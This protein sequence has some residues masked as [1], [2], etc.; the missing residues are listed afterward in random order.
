MDPLVKIKE[1]YDGGIIP[2]KTYSLI[3]KRFPITVSGINRV[4][5]ASGM[6]FPVAYVDP[7][8]TIT[9]PDPNSYQYGILFARTIPVIHEGRLQ[10]VIQISAP[11]VA[12]GLKGTV[13]AILAHEFLHYLE[14]VRRASQMEVVSD[15]ISASLFENVYADEARLFEPRV[16]FRDRTLLAHITKRFPSGFRDYRLEDKAVKLWVEKGLPKNTVTLDS[17][18]AKIPIDSISK[19]RLDPELAEK[20]GELQLKSEKIRAKKIY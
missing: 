2:E 5:K 18:T 19:I 20:I 16:V 8:I 12:Y 11:L 6:Q 7:S 10:V 9:A 3:R 14:L 1:A 15:E 13:H 4:E 17:N